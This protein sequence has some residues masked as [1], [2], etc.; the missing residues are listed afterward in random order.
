MW[1]DYIRPDLIREFEKEFNCK[2]VVD[3]YD[4][5]ESMYTK[6]L[7]GAEGYDIIFPS[8]YFLS[9]MVERGFVD[10]LDFTLIPNAKYIDWNRLKKWGLEPSEYGLPYM[11]SFSGLG[12]RADR[13]Q[14]PTSWSVFA[15]PHLRGRMTLLNDPRETIG[16][17]L[18]YLHYSVNSEDPIEINQARNVLLEWKQNLAKFESEQYKNG[19]ASAEFLVCHGYSSDLLQV[20]RE[21]PEVQFSYPVEGSVAS[22]D[23]LVVM[24]G[25]KDKALAHAFINFLH[26]A[27]NAKLNMLTTCAFCPNLEA[28]DAMTPDERMEGLRYPTKTMTT[29]EV[30]R[31]V[32]KAQGLYLKA[33]DE[34]KSR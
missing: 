31:H 10:K 29:P 3:T 34:V 28:L 8:T 5:N 30:I 11:I 33:W 17:A 16:A 24:K 7:F 26:S 27:K 21:L 2:V 4:T 18:R 32:H 14:K 25:C 9:L 13:T 15:D 23:S 6:L 19:I 12:Y 1:S 22:C 20:S